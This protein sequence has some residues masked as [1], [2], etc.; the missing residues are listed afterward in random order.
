[1][2]EIRAAAS[3]PAVA[4]VIAITNNHYRGQATVNALQLKAWVGGK[5]VKVPE[6]LKKAYPE[7]LAEIEAEPAEQPDLF[8]QEG[9]AGSS[10]VSR[11]RP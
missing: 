7:A 3:N 11:G 2:D 6:P 5:P 1:M 10:P 9:G 4:A 8:R